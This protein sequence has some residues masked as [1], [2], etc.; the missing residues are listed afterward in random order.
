VGEGWEG[1]QANKLEED[2]SLIDLIHINKNHPDF[3][4][5]TKYIV[6]LQS[7]KYGV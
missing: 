7:R 2:L 3:F 6:F 1:G 4:F 5:F